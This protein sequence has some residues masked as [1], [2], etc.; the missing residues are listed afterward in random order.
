M[1]HRTAR[2]LAVACAAALTTVAMAANNVQAAGQAAPS[3]RLDTIPSQKG[4]TP[5]RAWAINNLG[6]V[7]GQA[8]VKG[9]H[10]LSLFR[11]EK[12]KV[13]LLNDS[14]SA[15]A[16]GL[17]DAGEVAGTVTSGGD[18]L[19][20]MWSAAGDLQ[21]IGPA[22]STAH[23]INS[24]HQV[25][26][27]VTVEGQNHAALFENG[28]VT[29]LHQ[30]G[31][32]SV[33]TSINTE[34]K[35]VGYFMD[36]AGEP[37]AFAWQ[38][39]ELHEVCKVDGALRS[40]AR[41]VNHKG[42]VLCEVHLAAGNYTALI[43]DDDGTQHPVPGVHDDGLLPESMNNLGENTGRG[44]PRRTPYYSTGSKSY[45]L[46]KLVT[47]NGGDWA[48]LEYASDINRQAQI[49]GWGKTSSGPHRAYIATPLSAR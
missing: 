11:Y 35:V 34:G 14:R 40:Y 28:A 15:T 47:V 45:Y 30:L 48:Q 41:T 46:V 27:R 12:G 19:A 43:E 10:A 32:S 7:V 33:A 5:I 9:D 21:V 49:V 29:D 36:T 8:E 2:P 18:Y 37:H 22:G 24:N 4:V 42:Q 6:V 26:G 17:N 44:Y 38:N 16:S 20:V 25:V 39:G 23:A 3:Y 31:Q 13:T 1:S